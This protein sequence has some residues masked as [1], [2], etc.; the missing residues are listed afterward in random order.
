V[1]CEETGKAVTIYQFLSVCILSTFPP[2]RKVVR[3]GVIESLLDRRH[4]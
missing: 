3:S 2:R 4:S 1:V